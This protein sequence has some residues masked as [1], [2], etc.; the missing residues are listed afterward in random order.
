MRNAAPPML[1]SII[2][3]HARDNVSSRSRQSAVG[4]MRTQ[5]PT[6]QVM[7][8][9]PRLAAAA[10]LA[11]PIRRPGVFATTQ[12]QAAAEPLLLRFVNGEDVTARPMEPDEILALGDVFSRAVLL[13]GH[14][15]LTLRELHQA[16][17]AIEPKLPVRK[18][19]LVAEGAQF[20]AS[21]QTFELN[22]RLVFTWQASSSK[23]PDVM[24]STVASAD[25]GDSLLQLIAWSDTDRAF[26]FFERKDGAWAWA[27]NS[28]H[29]LAAATRGKG[30]FDSHINGG[31]VMK[32]LK[33]PWG[34]WHSMAGTIGRE[35][36]G[37]Q[38]EFNTDPLF[39]ELEGAQLLEN[40][41]RTGVRRWTN[42]RFGRD[43]VGGV[44][45]NLPQYMRQVLWCTSVNLVSSSDGFKSNEH[46]FDLPTS[47]FFDVEALELLTGIIDAM[48]DV[49]P[50]KRLHVAAP[51]YREAVAS[52]SIGVIDDSGE[53]RRIDGDT[54]F[55]FLVPERAFEDLTILNELIS[56]GVLSA[57]LALCLLLLDFS[58]PVFS[59]ERASLLRHAPESIA[60][61]Q[62]GKA[63]DEAF[64]AAVHATGA[65]AGSV[66]A[67]FLALWD[68]PDLLAHTADKLQAYHSALEVELG[69]QSGVEAIVDL[70]ESRRHAVRSTRS[71]AEFQSSMAQGTSPKPHL[72]MRPDGSVF[73]KTSTIGEGEF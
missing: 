22:A 33:A 58:N 17:A 12:P 14:N 8:K 10:A 56:R 13:R 28:F 25:S 1:F 27:G 26:H 31:L 7:S 48:R 18:M 36:F 69:S 42:G 55:A 23:P 35:V 34:H 30:P 62:D 24:L 51:L 64:L 20:A 21:G 70:A 6:R 61:G 49:I 73:T 63:L 4:H 52:R 67:A 40:I 57:K 3:S 47:F 29:A 53:R 44:L 5:F 38:T 32:E 11:R 39:S 2:D 71:L 68:T 16:I 54:H 43:L 37:A 50:G 15:P 72:A 59:P 9:A 46:E 66:E 19:F 45:Q 60:A 65:P 41:V